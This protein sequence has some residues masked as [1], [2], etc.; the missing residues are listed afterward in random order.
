M[1]RLFVSVVSCL[2][3]VVACS[4]KTNEQQVEEATHPVGEEQTSEEE[5]PDAPVGF[6]V[7][8]P[9]D[10]ELNEFGMITDMEDAGYPLY[11]VTIAFPER[12]SSNNFSLNAEEAALSHEASAYLE[13]YATIYYESEESTEVLD[14]IFN[15]QSLLGEYAPEDHEGLESFTGILRG[16]SSASGDLPSELKVEGEDSTLSFE[17]FVDEP[18]MTANDQSVTIYYY[19]RYVDVITYLELSEE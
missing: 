2:L 1:L 10:D 12:G 14:V 6:T 3:F 16:A 18:T 8:E 11:N 13:K 4:P 9:N 5:E 19:T 7:R 17:Y 15:G